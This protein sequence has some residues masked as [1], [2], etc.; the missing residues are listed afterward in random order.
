MSRH[1]AGVVGVPAASCE[2]RRVVITFWAPVYVTV[3]LDADSLDS[4]VSRVR[5]NDEIDTKWETATA[6]WGVVPGTRGAPDWTAGRITGVCADCNADVPHAVA[7]M[8]AAAADSSS[9]WPGW[10]FGA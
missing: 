7:E 5:V 8:A 1:A 3:D 6:D 4:A 10:E 2:H 9:S